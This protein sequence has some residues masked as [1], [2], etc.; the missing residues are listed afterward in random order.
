M[1]I[2][3]NIQAPS[4]FHKQ[5]SLNIHVRINVRT[6]WIFISI[7]DMKSGYEFYVNKNEIEIACL[8]KTHNSDIGFVHRCVL[9]VYAHTHTHLHIWYSYTSFNKFS[10]SIENRQTHSYT[11]DNQTKKKKKKHWKWVILPFYVALKVNYCT[12]HFLSSY[13]N[14]LIR[15]FTFV[16]WFYAS[17]WPQYNVSFNV[18]CYI[19]FVQILTFELATLDW[20]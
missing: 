11:F 1:N 9:C 20:N 4:I 16:K 13:W 19:H 10:I 12:C 5:F 3:I 2:F 17:I 7:K 8:F 18:L 15:Y 14:P 6:L